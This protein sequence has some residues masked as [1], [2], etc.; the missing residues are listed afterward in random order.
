MSK[1]A[2]FNSNYSRIDNFSGLR[3][4]EVIIKVMDTTA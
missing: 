1:N 2:N 3:D 4:P